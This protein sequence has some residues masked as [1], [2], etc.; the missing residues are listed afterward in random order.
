[1]KARLLEAGATLL[2]LSRSF[3]APPSIQAFVNGA[4][5]PVMTSTAD[6]AQADYV[7][8]SVKVVEI[9]VEFKVAIGQAANG[10]SLPSSASSRGC[11]SSAPSI[12]I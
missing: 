10:G 1:V 7:V 5:A 12:C 11:V 2:H 6:R 9:G 8:M 3:R 4:F